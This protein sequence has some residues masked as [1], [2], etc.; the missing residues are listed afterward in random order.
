MFCG[1]QLMVIYPYPQGLFP[2]HWVMY[3]IVQLTLKQPEQ[4]KS[5][6][7]KHNSNRMKS[8]RSMWMYHGIYYMSD[9]KSGNLQ[10]FLHGRSWISPGIKSISNELD[11]T[12]H[13]IASQ[14][15]GYC[16]VINKRLWHHRQNVNPA[17]AARG[18]RVKVVVFI[19]IFIVVMSC[20]KYNYVCTLVTNCFCAQPSVIL[21]FI[22]T[23][24]TLSRALKQFVTRVHTLFSI[25]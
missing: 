4:Y 25:Y 10:I 7:T 13:V 22:C 18:R 11:I 6:K 17:S 23:K 15:S 20:K 5:I 9:Y 21:V 24:I 12:I 3:T 1:C 8:S 2:W 14:L 19:A 16:D